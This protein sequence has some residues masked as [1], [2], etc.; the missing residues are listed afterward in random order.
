M[1]VEDA[2]QAR[3]SWRWTVAA[4]TLAAVEGHPGGGGGNPVVEAAAVG[5]TYPRRRQEDSA[6]DGRQDRRA[7]SRSRKKQNVAQ[8]YN[9]I[10]EGLRAQYRLGYSPDQAHSG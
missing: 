4:N 7:L 8:I 9:Q 5:R 3:G 1:E 2:I 10:A 6:A